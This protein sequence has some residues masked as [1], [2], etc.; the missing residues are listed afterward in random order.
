MKSVRTNADGRTDDVILK[1]ED[2][3]VGQYE[4][5]FHVDDYFRSQGMSLAD[6]PFID[7]P[8]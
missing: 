5:L 7:R 4:L 2:T 8:F 3:K 6:P 1:P